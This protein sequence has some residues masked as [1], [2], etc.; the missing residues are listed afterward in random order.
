MLNNT[1]FGLVWALS[2]LYLITAVKSS[3]YFGTA[4]VLLLIYLDECLNHQTAQ[5]FL[6]IFIRI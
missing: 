4:S 1:D 5:H 2:G 3:N 6:V